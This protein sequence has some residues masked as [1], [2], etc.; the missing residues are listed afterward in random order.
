MDLIDENE[1]H[2]IVEE[3]LSAPFTSIKVNIDDL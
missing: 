3:R 1:L 2:K